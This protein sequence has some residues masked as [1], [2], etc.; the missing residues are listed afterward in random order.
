LFGAAPE[1]VFA[2][3][4]SSNDPRFKEVA[5]SVSVTMRFSGGRLASF[6]CGFG[7]TKVSEYRVVGTEGILIMDPACT[8]HD[9]IHQTIVV[10]EKLKKRV[11]EHRDQVAAEI[12]YFADCIQNG[13]DFDS[14]PRCRLAWPRS[15][16]Q[17][18]SF[19]RRARR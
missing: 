12:L 10:G 11:F 3:D 2:F 16:N 9:A 7:A 5:E 13:E 1:E 15:M 17:R 14:L 4:A 8:W 18:R 19:F 6:V